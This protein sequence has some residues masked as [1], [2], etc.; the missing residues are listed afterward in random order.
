MQMGTLSLLTLDSLRRS[1]AQKIKQENALEDEEDVHSSP[2]NRSNAPDSTEKSHFRARTKLL[3]NGK[4]DGKEARA[5]A[6]RI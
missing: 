4:S 5:N 2:N 6:K 1:R 3:M